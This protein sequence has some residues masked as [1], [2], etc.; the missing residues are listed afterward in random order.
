[1]SEHDLSDVDD[2]LLPDGYR[3]T[4]SDDYTVPE[5]VVGAW[6]EAFAEDGAARVILVAIVALYTIPFLPLW[7]LLWAL[8]ELGVWEI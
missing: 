5:V 6:R 3:E 1:M 2:E 8:D 4:A 7:L